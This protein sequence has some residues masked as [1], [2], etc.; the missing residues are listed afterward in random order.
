MSFRRRG[1]ALDV[2][3]NS[4]GRPSCA[5]VVVVDD[6]ASFFTGAFEVEVGGW[7]LDL[8]LALELVVVVVVVFLS[9]RSVAADA[10][11]ADCTSGRM[12]SSTLLKKKKFVSREAR[13]PIFTLFEKER[14]RLP[15]EMLERFPGLNLNSVNRKIFFPLPPRLRGSPA[16]LLC[17]RTSRVRATFLAWW[18]FRCAYA[19]ALIVSSICPFNLQP[20]TFLSIFCA[21]LRGIQH[22]RS[23][24][25]DAL[26][27][28]ARAV[29]SIAGWGEICAS[30]EMRGR[31]GGWISWSGLC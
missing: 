31:S 13:P 4:L 8:D 9:L 28:D 2:V 10:R 30:N 24:L 6:G 27:A 15:I 1:A 29:T 11:I 19:L 20:R 16:L 26:C 3:A 18:R 14:K 21:D 22:A 23:G 5:V 7:D 12:W 17:A 25:G